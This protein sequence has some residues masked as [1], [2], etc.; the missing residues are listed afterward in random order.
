MSPHIMV[1]RRKGF[2]MLHDLCSLLTPLMALTIEEGEK[3]IT[4]SSVIPRW[5]EAMKGIDA[6][7]AEAEANR[8][9]N[10][11][12]IPPKLVKSWKSTVDSLW[13]VY[14]AGF[15]EDPIFLVATILD[16]RFCLGV[17]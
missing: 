8:T 14:V 5:I 12:I 4:S 15:L 3:Y 16:V 9:G 10:G 2:D 7:T 11:L 13:D 6:V 17:I 1:L